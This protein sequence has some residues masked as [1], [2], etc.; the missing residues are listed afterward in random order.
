MLISGVA[1][2]CNARAIESAD[3][4]IFAFFPNFRANSLFLSSIHNYTLRAWYSS[5]LKKVY[6]C[7]GSTRQ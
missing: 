4:Q 6:T 1:N 7:G 2:Q 5:C 3:I